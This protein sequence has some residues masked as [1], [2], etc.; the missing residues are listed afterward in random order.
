MDS[1]LELT[2]KIRA[3][4][5]GE[6]IPESNNLSAYWKMVHYRAGFRYEHLG[7]K[8]AESELKEYAVF[9]WFWITFKKK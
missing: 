6:Y 4:I 1:N 8:F 7:M 3:A 9:Y 5:G 2:N